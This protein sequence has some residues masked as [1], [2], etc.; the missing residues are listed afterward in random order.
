MQFNEYQE[1]ASRTEKVL[2]KFERVVHAQLGTSSE[3]GEIADAIKKH[4]IYGKELDVANIKEEVGDMMWYLAL[5]ANALDFTLEDAA[6]ENIEKL[7]KRYPEKYTDQL[8]V[9]RLDKKGI[10]ETNNG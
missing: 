5:F 2:T 6:K 7:R 10:G 4:Y 3:S 8:A 1:L 9:E